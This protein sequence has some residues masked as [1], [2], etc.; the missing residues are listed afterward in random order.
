MGLFLNFAVCQEEY[1]RQ[2]LVQVYAEKDRYGWAHVT[3]KAT[4]VLLDYSSPNIAK[5]FH[6]GHLR[7]TLLGNFVKRIHEVM[8]YTVVSVNYL[9]DW[10]KQYGKSPCSFI[11][12]RL[13]F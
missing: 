7:S 10:G 5:P 6:A 13:F 8:G 2:T 1:I 4:R 11:G 12:R 3:N 9:G